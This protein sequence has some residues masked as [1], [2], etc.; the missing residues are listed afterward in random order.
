M[1]KRQALGLFENWGQAFYRCQEACKVKLPMEG[2]V[3]I[4]VADKDKDD[5]IDVAQGFVDCDFRI[6]ATQGTAAAIREA[7]LPCD[8][9]YK[10]HEGR[11][12]INDAITNGEIDLI[13][14]TPSG[15]MSTI[16]DS[17]IRKNAIKHRIPYMT[18]MVAA[19]AT[20]VGIKAEKDGHGD[21][22]KS[23]QEYHAAIQD[24]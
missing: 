10:I 19:K 12:S 4:S 11:P 20:A 2:T 16:D 3:L 23:L 21:P 8:S 1:Y 15:K 17:Y 9:I 14:N 6:L 18:T 5:L 7:G 13:I 22:V 24:A